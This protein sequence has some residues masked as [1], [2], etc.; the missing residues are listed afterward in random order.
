MQHAGRE[1]SKQVWWV[2]LRQFRFGVVYI[3]SWRGSDATKSR[4]EECAPKRSVVRT[5]SEGVVRV[6]RAE[7][8]TE[9]T[10]TRDEECAPTSSVV[11]TYL[12]GVV[13]VVRVRRLTGG[14]PAISLLLWSPLKEEGR[15]LH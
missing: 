6:V 7:R 12:K 11:R 1:R 13:R 14:A 3:A 5:C 10:K 4:D 15:S 8:P 9:G 2:G